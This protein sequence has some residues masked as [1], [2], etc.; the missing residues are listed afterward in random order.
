[1]DR[2]KFQNYTAFESGEIELRPLT[3]LLGANSS[4]KSSISR[5]LYYAFKYANDY[6]SIANSS[7]ILELRPIDRL[8]HNSTMEFRRNEFLGEM[9]HYYRMA[10]ESSSLEVKVNSYCVALE[11]FKEFVTKNE[12]N[13]DS[14]NESALARFRSIIEGSILG[15]KKWQEYPTK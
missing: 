13:K 11:L 12:S 1:M 5:L 4:G 6:E 2:I 10:D 8:V 9:R 7:A 14:I 15:K 3:L